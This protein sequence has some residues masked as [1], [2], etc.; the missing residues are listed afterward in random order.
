MDPRHLLQ[1]NNMH[2]SNSTFVADLA[3]AAARAV[4]AEHIL[5]VTNVDARLAATFEAEASLPVTSRVCS[6]VPPDSD[7]Y[8]CARASALVLSTMSSFSQHIAVQARPGTP[9]VFMGDCKK[10]VVGWRS[11]LLGRPHFSHGAHRSVCRYGISAGPDAAE[12]NRSCA[13]WLG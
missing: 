8:A 2:M 9:Y 11:C 6:Q 3:A 1:Y 10:E 5:L 13:A 7:K 4:G 12:P